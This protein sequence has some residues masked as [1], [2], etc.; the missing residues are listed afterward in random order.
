MTIEIQSHSKNWKRKY[1]LERKVLEDI[2]GKEI[3]AIEHIGSTSVPKLS[4]KPIIDIFLA[5]SPLHN[6]SYYNDKLQG[7]NYRY[8]ITDMS[9][10]HLF[11]KYTAAEVWTHNLHILPYDK[12][13]YLRSE[14]LFRDY[15]RKNPEFVSKYTSLK[16][17]LVLKN[18]NNIEEYTKSKS[19]FIGFVMELARTEKGL[20]K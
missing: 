3:K 4:A 16:E 10:R 13:F 5:V 15:L 14:L 19:E 7:L 8:S 20:V 11:S 2:F 12:N 1:E 17:Q 6:V 18:Y 9:N